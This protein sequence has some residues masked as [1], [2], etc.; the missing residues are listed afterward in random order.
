MLN[1]I[2]ARDIS[3]VAEPVQND[4]APVAWQSHDSLVS[5]EMNSAPGPQP[6]KLIVTHPD[7]YIPYKHHNIITQLFLFVI[8]LQSLMSTGPQ[9]IIS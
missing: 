9:M 1:S 5:Y 6:D 4:V 2:T 8:I 3:A 7:K